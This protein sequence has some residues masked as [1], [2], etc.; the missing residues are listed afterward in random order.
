M[1]SS[2][3][4]RSG[5]RFACVGLMVVLC[6]GLSGC[7]GAPQLMPTPNVYSNGD[8]DPFPDVPPELQNNHVEVLYFTDRALDADSSPPGSY[9]YRRS[10]SVAFGVSDVQFGKDV[11]WADLNKASRAAKRS[12]DLAVTVAKS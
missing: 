3:H 11:S 6:I 8:R 7:G 5:F 1:N 10:R 12:V 4:A 9:G 2:E